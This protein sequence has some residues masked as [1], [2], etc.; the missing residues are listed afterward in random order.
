M[1]VYLLEFLLLEFLLPYRE[2]LDIMMPLRTLVFL[3]AMPR[4]QVAF[5]LFPK[6][7]IALLGWLKGPMHLWYISPQMRQ[8]VKLVCCSH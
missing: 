7:Q 2:D 1:N 5:I 4:S 3:P 8:K 6:R